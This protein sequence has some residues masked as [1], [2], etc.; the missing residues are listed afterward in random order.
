[1]EPELVP[2]TR[3]RYVT[4]KETD[5]IYCDKEKKIVPK[6]KID[7]EAYGKPMTLI[8]CLMQEANE[9]IPHVHRLSTTCP[10]GK[11][12]DDC[13]IFQ[14]DMGGKIEPFAMKTG[15]KVLATQKNK[16]N[17]EQ[18]A[19]DF[20][21]RCAL[22]KVD[23]SLAKESL[24]K[25]DRSKVRLSFRLYD[26]NELAEENSPKPLSKKDFIIVDSCA[27]EK[28]NYDIRH[29]QPESKEASGGGELIVVCEKVTK[30]DCMVCFTDPN[31]PDWKHQFIPD[32]DS[33]KLFSNTTFVIANVPPFHNDN[34][35]QV[36]ISVQHKGKSKKEVTF[37]IFLYTPTRS[38][39]SGTSAIA[40]S[41]NH[42][43]NTSPNMQ[44]RP[45]P[46]TSTPP[47][48][49]VKPKG[50][51]HPRWQ[52]QSPGAAAVRTRSMISSNSSSMG[53]DKPTPNKRPISANAAKMAESQEGVSLTQDP[54]RSKVL[55]WSG[56]NDD[57]GHGIVGFHA[58]PIAGAAATDYSVQETEAAGDSHEKIDEKLEQFYDEIRSTGQRRSLPRPGEQHESEH[59]LHQA[60]GSGA[61]SQNASMNSGAL[62]GSVIAGS[63]VGSLAE[64]LGSGLSLGLSD[65]AKQELKDVD[66]THVTFNF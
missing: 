9:D 55:Q 1:M 49:T 36:Q 27:T 44:I 56:F 59:A 6:V 57:F 62:S 54:S 17:R 38:S 46:D 30:N 53:S 35:G 48:V 8:V 3:F 52:E 19:R 28:A 42:N 20:S 12:L 51:N 41:Q 23:E 26:K 60:V 22:L 31:R 10:N 14:R 66:V 13:H 39:R 4:E 33:C 50:R 18:Q 64:S 65:D 63:D 11:L 34:G 43:S 2:E 29:F 37:R 5:Y 7:Y 16:G 15:V 45:T 58:P 32:G 61:A 21:N 40:D 25:I 24:K 47:V